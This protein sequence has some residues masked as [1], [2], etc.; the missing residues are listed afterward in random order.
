MWKVGLDPLEDP[1]V[2]AYGKL[3]IGLSGLGLEIVG[4]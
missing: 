1:G 3:S 2:A 4:F